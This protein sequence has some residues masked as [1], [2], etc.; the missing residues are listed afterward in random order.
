MLGRIGQRQQLLKR[1][2]EIVGNSAA[3]AAV[4]EFNDA[5]LAAVGG[6]A[7]LENFAVDADITELVNDDG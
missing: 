4:G 2:Y 1:G 3:D 7:R 5:I 6:A